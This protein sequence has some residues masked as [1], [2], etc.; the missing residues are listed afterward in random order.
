[1][2]IGFQRPTPAERS[3]YLLYAALLTGFFGVAIMA[4][5]FL[6][7]RLLPFCIFHHLTGIP[8]PTCGVCR[9]W[10]LILG[11]QWG[12]AI[13]MQ[14]LVMLLLAGAA[15]WTGYAWI[16]AL[17][18]LPRPVPGPVSRGTKLAIACGFIALVLINW[19]YLILSRI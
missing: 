6:P 19:A 15:V 16:V 10:R 13:R 18:R 5:L 8:C 7:A 4:G 17:L 2:K 9:S 3:T 1:M 11:G 12:A 14:P